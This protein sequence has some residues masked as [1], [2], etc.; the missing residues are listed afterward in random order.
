MTAAESGSQSNDLYAGR[1]QNPPEF[2]TSAFRQ[3]RFFFF[4]GNTSINGKMPVY[5]YTTE[6]SVQE[7]VPESMRRASVYQNRR[8]NALSVIP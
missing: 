7:N 4:S 5:I 2:Q 8:N 3:Y 1:R 6:G